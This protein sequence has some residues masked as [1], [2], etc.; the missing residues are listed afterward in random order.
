MTLAWFGLLVAVLAVIRTSGR[1]S[2]RRVPARW[3]S[4][5]PLN[6]HDDRA[7]DRRLSQLERMVAHGN[8]LP[9]HQTVAELAR[10]L[11]ESESVILRLNLEDVGSER[12]DARIRAF[13]DRP[14]LDSP[15]RYRRELS[16]VLTRLEQL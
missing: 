16:D 6:L 1:L 15:D 8:L 10:R 14:P 3:P 2:G 4:E 13:L 5:A 9:A 11:A 12:L 7:R